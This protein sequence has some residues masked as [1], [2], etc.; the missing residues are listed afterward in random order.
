MYFFSRIFVAKI[1]G[2]VESGVYWTIFVF[3]PKDSEI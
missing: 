3:V 2:F 1:L